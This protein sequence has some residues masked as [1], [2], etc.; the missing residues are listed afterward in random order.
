MPHRS[1]FLDH[2][3]RQRLP[4]FR[5]I[6]DRR[7]AATRLPQC[8]SRTFGPM[9]LSI[10]MHEGGAFARGCCGRRRCFS[11]R[12]TEYECKEGGRARRVYVRQ[13][14]PPG[15]EVS[16]ATW[17]RW[18]ALFFRPPFL[19]PLDTAPADAKHDAFRFAFSRGDGCRFISYPSSPVARFW[20]R[21][22]RT[23]MWC[24]LLILLVFAQ[25]LRPSLGLHDSGT[26]P[27]P[28]LLMEPARSPF[29]PT[30]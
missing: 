2:A 3:Q 29:A 5:T 27:S 16:G 26:S 17:A 11:S 1:R 23:V 24:G 9:T 21:S 13:R 25:R 7:R 10:A 14:G 4:L 6:Q 22:R 8:L 15:H 19:L 20:C 18:A 30:R 12:F 28:A